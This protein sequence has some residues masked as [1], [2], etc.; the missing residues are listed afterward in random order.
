MD[1][2]KIM[3]PEGIRFVDQHG[4]SVQFRTVIAMIYDKHTDC[5]YLSEY[6][7]HKIKKINMKDKIVQTIAG[8]GIQGFKDGTQI[9]DVYGM[10]MRNEDILFTDYNFADS[11]TCIRK[12]TKDGLITTLYAQSDGFFCGIFYEPLSDMTIFSD[13]FNDKMMVLDK[14]DKMFDLKLK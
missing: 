14:T 6:D 8:N 7:V 5:L 13:A 3:E 1:Q 4:K 11:K 12:M 10:T 9:G 2:I